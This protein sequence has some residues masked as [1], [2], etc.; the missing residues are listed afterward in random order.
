MFDG[1]P[2]EPNYTP[3]GGPNYAPENKGFNAGDLRAR[4][5]GIGGG[6]GEGITGAKK[7]IPIIIVII[8]VLAAAFFAYTYFASQKSVT[9]NLVDADGG[10]VQGKITL[11]DSSQKL[12]QTTPKDASSTF[13]ANIP[14]G[15]YRL[16]ATAAGYKSTITT[17]SVT[18]DNTS[19]DT[20]M[21][22]D[23]RAALTMEFDATQIFDGQTISGKIYATNSGPEFKTTDI[24]STSDAP[25]DVKIIYPSAQVLNTG[26]SVYIDFNATI[27]SASPLTA[28]KSVTLQFK[29]KGSAITSNA[30]ELTALPAVAAR[31]ITL[32][33]SLNSTSL[34]AGD[35]KPFTITVKN[36][37]K[38][39]P[40]ENV[41]LEV[42]PD[43]DSTDMLSWFRFIDP[44]AD[45]NYIKVI[46][47]IDPT[48]SETATLYVKPP[49]TSKK[50]DTFKGTLKI[51]SISLNGD[52]TPLQMNFSVATEKTA[53]VNLVGVDSPFNI[54]CPKS[55]GACETK[56]L[57][58]GQVYLINNGNVDVGPIQVEI[59]QTTPTTP[60][61]FSFLVNSVLTLDSNSNTVETLSANSQL[62]T[63]KETILIDLTAPA[64][65]GA[66]TAK[67][68]IS[69]KYVDPLSDPPNTVTGMKIIQINSVVN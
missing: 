31:D 15:D 53:I 67:C 21:T 14:E 13:T 44:S 47:N 63:H 37:N 25:L 32:S 51:T 68:A 29:I 34:V 28:Q 22:R 48:K 9:I 23:L 3:G 43:P 66:Q 55:G 16:T 62:P 52:K 41:T 39:T 42:V 30:I 27:K 17:I 60:N 38:N 18:S 40:L 4:F 2:D 64:G 8:I 36:G 20:N 10:P 56:N 59:L 26:G 11:K 69:W 24:V 65:I 57:D 61:C 5:D 33:G 7:L 1:S 54:N 50:G 35:E 46:E 45:G 49:I 58:S 19:F 12:I 6:M